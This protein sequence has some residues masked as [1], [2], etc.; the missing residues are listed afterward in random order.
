MGKGRGERDRTAW[1]RC[2]VLRRV[3][4]AGYKSFGPWG[5]VRGERGALVPVQ[6]VLNGVEQLLPACLLGR[7]RRQVQLE[8]AGGRKRQ[9]LIGVSAHVLRVHHEAM[10]R[11]ADWHAG[12]TPHEE[13]E[14][15]ALIAAHLAQH[16]PQEGDGPRVGCPHLGP[17]AQNVDAPVRL[18]AHEPLNLVGRAQDERLERHNLGQP[19]AHRRRLRVALMQPVRARPVAPVGASGV[20]QRH[21]GAAGQQLDRGEAVGPVH[22]E[23]H[24]V[25]VHGVEGRLV[26]VRT[27]RVRV[28]PHLLHQLHK[29]LVDARVGAE[30][31]HLA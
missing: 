29:R 18:A 14:E 11:L 24:A 13:E 3:P 4:R 2:D 27:R 7:V 9:V 17:S 6:G 8:E 21:C 23:G 31:Q 26:H 12:A 22:G 20:G 25:A 28:V 10:G 1:D 30:G 19:R 16:L 15:L 5:F